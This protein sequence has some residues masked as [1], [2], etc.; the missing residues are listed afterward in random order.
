MTGSTGTHAA[1]RGA[2]SLRASRA[3]L[4]IVAL[5]ILLGFAFQGSRGLWG[6]D[7]GR[8]VDA[9]L[10]MMD[11]G[12]YMAPA[13]SPAELN[14]SKPPL[15]YW[16]IAGSMQLFGRNVWAARLP[17]ALAYLATL[18]V[19]FAMGRKACPDR[20]WLAPL[21]YATS[22]FGFLASNII[23]TD[24]LLTLAEGLAVLGFMMYAWPDSALQARRGH[25]L[26]W[27]GF[28]LAFLV[29]GP[30][31]L[32]P[33]LAII[34]F[35][36]LC[37]DWRAVGRL[38][39]PTGLLLFLAVGFTWYALAISRYPWLLH[40]FI[41][42]EVYGRIFT[43]MYVRHS[44]AFGWFLVYAPVLVFGS[45]PWWR[46]AMHAVKAA[47]SPSSWRTWREARS[48]QLFLLLWFVIPFVIFCVAKSRLPLYLLPLFLPLALLVA[49]CMAPTFDLSLRRNTLLLAAWVV[50]LLAIKALPAYGYGADIDDGAGARQVATAAGTD[51]HALIFVEKA[52]DSYAIEE[53]TPWGMRLYLSKPVYGVRWMDADAAAQICSAIKAQ[54]RSLLLVD[55]TITR[56]DL[57]DALVHCRASATPVGAWRKDLLFVVGI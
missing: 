13:Y 44:G 19:L 11:S 35:T 3:W 56:K 54:G 21:V 57:E 37:D 31:G 49:S 1:D 2:G 53:Q 47:A 30:P 5:G 38:F 50:V 45:L 51:Y 29:K 23:S 46:G 12:N 22:V 39:A 43:H 34:A 7:E 40:Y 15:T 41:H 20:P 48:V 27:L 10:Q 4:W 17:Y 24:V 16:V 14:F 36:A 52:T 32:L 26:M 33:L 25:W 8:Y 55:H 6:P 18:L 9:A 42:D 28:G